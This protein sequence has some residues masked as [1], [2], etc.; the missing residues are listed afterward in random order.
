[1]FHVYEMNMGVATCF[2]IFGGEKLMDFQYES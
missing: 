1:M 2:I